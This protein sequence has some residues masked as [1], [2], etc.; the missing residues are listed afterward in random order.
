MDGRWGIRS[1]NPSG[2]RM[3]IAMQFLRTGF[4]FVLMATSICARANPAATKPKAVGLAGS[5]SSQKDQDRLRKEQLRIFQE[6]VLTRVLSNIQ[7]MDEVALR[8]SARN[9]ILKYL[10]KLKPQAESNKLAALKLAQEAL[11][12]IEDHRL[13]IPP[14]MTDYL[15]GDLG[16][17]IEQ[18]EP[19]LTR[20]F[21]TI[22]HSGETDEVSALLGM[23]DGERLAS[24]KIRQQL[25][26]G[27]DLNSLG[28][29]LQELSIR[30]SSQ[31]D[32]LLSHIL[33]VAARDY[34][35]SIETLNNIRQVF[36]ELHVSSGLRQRFLSVVVARTHPA[37]L[38]GDMSRQSGYELLIASLPSI[39]KLTPALYS[40]ALSQ[41]FILRTALTKAQL[42]SDA[43]RKRLSD[44]Q[45]PIEDLI[46]EADQAKSKL[47]RNSLLAD[48]AQMALEQNKMALS[49]EIVTKLNFDESLNDFW[50]G[51]ADQFLKDVIRT[52]LRL[53]D[54]QL[55]QKA[56]SLISSPFNKIEGLVLIFQQAQQN[57]DELT[58]GR[59][60]QEATKVADSDFDPL[61]KARAFFMLSIASEGI[62][63]S[64]TG[65]LL[66]SGI[67]T[68][69]SVVQPDSGAP[70]RQTHD[71]FVRSLSF[72]AQ[73]L[74][75]SFK[76]L[77]KTDQNR[78]LALAEQIQKPD[79][80]SFA[81]IGIIL[82][83][84][85]TLSSGQ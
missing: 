2:R 57:R 25:D 69:N 12:D 73:S 81:M 66:E 43:R 17:W 27:R 30:N 44:S 5:R 76:T 34:I 38:V 84:D 33:D 40:Q 35:P 14:T 1:E 36:L 23:K 83:V 54:L 75:M 26:G 47:E 70:D 53:K 24:E 52:A 13:E 79:L 37:L 68:L 56:A 20:R 80:R 55:A 49:V 9:Q 15:L 61:Q 77:S 48:G 74:T 32:P 28:F 60:F 51:W 71:Q 21:L 4:T 8:L 39:E 82:G 65:T 58:G 7:K 16:A 63:A 10:V 62:D 59:V 78:A 85:Q 46:Q 50:R 29:Y 11:E 3:L 67:K 45:N 72:E 42:D 64:R 31:L 41:A 19:G 6:H 18:H 22:N